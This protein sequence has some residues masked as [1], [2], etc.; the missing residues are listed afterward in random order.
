MQISLVAIAPVIEI[1]ISIADDSET[2]FWYK[3]N[4]RARPYP[5]SF[6]RIA[7]KT[8]EPAIGASTW[9]FGNHRWVE[10]IGNLTKKPINIIIQNIDLKEKKCGNINSDGIDIRTLFE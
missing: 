7:A 5:P 8:I 1:L 3:Y 10:N 6:K 2:I 4:I 9:A